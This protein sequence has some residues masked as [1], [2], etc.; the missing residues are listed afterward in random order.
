MANALGVYRTIQSSEDG[1]EVYYLHDAPTMAESTVIW[2]FNAG[3]FA[4]STDGGQ[5]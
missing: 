2:E 1:S 4:V 5:T 3:A